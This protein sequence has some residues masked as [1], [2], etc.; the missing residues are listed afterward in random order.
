MA[1]HEFFQVRVECEYSVM[2]LPKD[3]ATFDG[4][5]LLRV[6][7]ECEERFIDFD[8][9]RYH[10]NARLLARDPE[11]PG[12]SMQPVMLEYG[13]YWPELEPICASL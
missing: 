10:Y 1:Y 9:A 3:K 5:C 2:H 8:L 11:G 7:R 12:R 13:Y 6:K 4:W